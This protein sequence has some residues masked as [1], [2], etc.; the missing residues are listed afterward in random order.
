MLLPLYGSRAVSQPLQSNVRN[1]LLRT[2]EPADFASLAPH[3]EP[4]A[5]PLRHVLIA[6]L[7][8]ITHMHFVEEGLVS[9][10]SDTAEN[11]IEIGVVGYEGLAGVSLVLGADRTPHVALVQ[12]DLTALRIP[13]DCVVAA[14]AA[15]PTLRSVL[16]R[17]VQSLMVQVGQTVHANADLT[18]EG[19]LAR[20][21]LMNH[22]RLGHD[23]LPLTHEFL[24][25]MLGVR[26]PGVTTATH[27]L[28]GAG[29]IRTK[30]GRIIVIDREKLMDLA[31]DAYG[32]AEAEYER[33]LGGVKSP[34][35]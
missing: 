25:I 18:I 2:M 11:R 4:I 12:A 10:I 15:S 1:R 13:A 8:P 7:E 20:W 6:P 28:E 27:I 23:E 32:L 34:A 26:R 31:G 17:Y 14:L 21:I 33:L 19:R 5:A 3:L 24:A 22:D 29:M 30:R 9:L 35:P 16:G